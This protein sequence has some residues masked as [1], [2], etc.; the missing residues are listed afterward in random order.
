MRLGNPGHGTILIERPQ[1]S[2][3]RSVDDILIIFDNSLHS[4]VV[5]V[6]GLIVAATFEAPLVR[7][8]DLLEPD[9][10]KR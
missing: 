8:P 5:V 1:K 10:S 9:K 6:V 7:A 2:K 4:L 3:T